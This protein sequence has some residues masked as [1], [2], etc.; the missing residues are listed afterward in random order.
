MGCPAPGWMGRTPLGGEPLDQP[1]LVLRH[2][3]P[4]P[5]H[6]PRGD[7]R[8]SFLTPNAKLLSLQV[9]KRTPLEPIHKFQGILGRSD[10]DY[11]YRAGRTTFDS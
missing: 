6:Q 3:P 4:S 5:Q 9:R 7:W 10:L 2:T 8:A 11:P 1:S